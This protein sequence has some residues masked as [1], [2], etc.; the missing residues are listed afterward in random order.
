VENEPGLN[1]SANK[2]IH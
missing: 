1:Y 2:K